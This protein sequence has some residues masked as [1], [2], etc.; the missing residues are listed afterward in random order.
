MSFS[1]CALNLKGMSKLFSGVS[2][3]YRSV[4]GREERVQWWE[5]HTT[6]RVSLRLVVDAPNAR[7]CCLT[8]GR[9]ALGAALNTEGI[10]FEAIVDQL[11]RIEESGTLFQLDEVVEVAL[12]QRSLAG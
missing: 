5:A 9:K 2:R 12:A 11:S 7:V 8:A 4:S 10:S 3:C 1:F 6:K